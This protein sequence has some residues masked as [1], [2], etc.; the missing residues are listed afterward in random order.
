LTSQE[1]KL[2]FD[3]YL[4]PDEVEKELFGANTSQM[5]LACEVKDYGNFIDTADCQLIFN[6]P[7][8]GACKQELSL[9]LS[10]IRTISKALQAKIHVESK[11]QNT[12]FTLVMKI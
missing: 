9:N 2:N 12:K 8:Q 3:D 10:N 6:P 1:L 5:Y 11:L 7:K 4:T